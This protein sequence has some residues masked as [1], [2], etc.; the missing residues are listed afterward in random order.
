MRLLLVLLFAASAASAQ[1]ANL[2]QTPSSLLTAAKRVRDTEPEK[3]LELTRTAL[4]RMNQATDRLLWRQAQMM[5]CRL[6]V[7]LTSDSM[8]VWADAALAVARSSHDPVALAKAQACKGYAVDNLI[9]DSK[10][11]LAYYDSAVAAGQKFDNDTILADA[12]VGRGELHYSRGDFVTSVSDLTRAYRLFTRMNIPARKVYALTA[13]ANLYADARVGQYDKALEYYQQVLAAHE[14]AG[15]QAGIAETYFNIAG[16]LERKERQEEA[17]DY[18]RKALAIDS[19]RNDPDEVAYDRRAIGVVLYHLNRPQEAIVVIDKALAQFKK[20][21]NP[22]LIAMTRLARGAALRLLHRV[23]E[24]IKELEFARDYYIKNENNRFLEWTYDYLA[25]SYALGGRYE[26]AYKTNMAQLAVQKKLNEQALD[27]RTARMRVQF[28]A[29]KK[30]QENRAL[31]RENAAIARVRQLQFA[32]LVLT[33]LIIAVLFVFALRQIKSTRRLRIT[34]MTDDLTGMP[35]RRHLLHVAEEQ[36]EIAR[37]ARSPLGVLGIDIDHF[38]Q[39]NDN[40]GHAVGD[41]ALRRVSNT[42]Q[43]TLRGADMVGRV[44][45]DEFIVIL[46]GA[47]RSVADDVATR[48]HAAIAATDFADLHPNLLV[49]LCIGVAVIEESDSSVAEIMKRADESLYAA[50]GAGR[51]RVAALAN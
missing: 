4:G 19:A 25:Q 31:E 10:I 50:K 14:K 2:S 20:T 38:K 46:P 48:I 40:F 26:D 43:A 45:G 42:L 32:V 51:N 27:E 17:L 13:L 18:Y 47:Q 7:E 35:N 49:T 6:G 34:A 23:P 1:N 5:R 37:E 16:T 33:S 24:A 12:Q 30:E 22:F 39:I 36:F 28:D 21:G 44:G 29:E 3:A 8:D 15:N 9:G 11:A 41:E